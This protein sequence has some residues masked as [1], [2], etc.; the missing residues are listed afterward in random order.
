MTR[1]Q[2]VGTSKANSS[3]MLARNIKQIQNMSYLKSSSSYT[4]SKYILASLMEHCK[5]TFNDSEK[6]FIWRVGG[7]P[8]PMCVVSTDV[9]FSELEQF[10]CRNPQGLNSVV[11]V[12][13]TFNFGE[14]YFTPIT[15]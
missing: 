7:A 2:L 13:P 12:D 1:K 10:C 9:A 15:F 4:S 5:T 14:F 8:E 6:S 3:R 11:T